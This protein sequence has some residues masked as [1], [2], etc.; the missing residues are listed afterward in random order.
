[1]DNRIIGV[2]R[3]KNPIYD[4]ENEI[5]SRKSRAQ[6]IRMEMKQVA[7]Q[8]LKFL[9][10]PKR[11]LFGNIEFA[12][13]LILRF[14]N[15]EDIFECLVVSKEYYSLVAYSVFWSEEKIKSGFI[16]KKKQSFFATGYK[17][18]GLHYFE[19]SLSQNNAIDSPKYK[20]W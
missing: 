19:K 6:R 3:L 15:M 12:I 20:N 11:S 4:Y 17:L 8:R 1:M 7:K 10:T 13:P 2:E 9:D 5:L 16:S 14:M 18:Q